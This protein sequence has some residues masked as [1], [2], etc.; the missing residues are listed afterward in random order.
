MTIL[1]VS[2]TGG[3]V[4]RVALACPSY[5]NQIHTG[6]AR[7]ILS[8]TLD[9]LAPGRPRV[10][11]HVWNSAS[12]LAH[13]FNNALRAALDARDDTTIP[14]DERPTHFVMLHADLEPVGRDWMA[15]LWSVMQREGCDVLSAVVPIK[16]PTR[17]R[18]STAIGDRSDDWKVN[19]H[20]TAADLGKTP[21]T[22]RGRDVCGPGEVLL[23]NTGLWMADLRRSFWDD[24][25]GFQIRDRITRDESGRRVCQVRPEDWEFSRWLDSV[26]ADYAATWEIPV[27]H[28]GEEGWP[29]YA[30][31]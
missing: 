9:G 31:E 15:R 22:F 13:N 24:F 21:P 26:G 19:R 27:H 8:A 16:E 5:C 3:F 17:E 23:V 18:T 20:I 12:L 30:P 29:N 1:P 7:A 6:S 11:A 25:P 4:P 28:Y 14:N 10:V 2:A